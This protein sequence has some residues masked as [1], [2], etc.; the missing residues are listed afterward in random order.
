MTN[1]IG[2]RFGLLVSITELEPIMR[3]NG[4]KRRY[5]Q[6]RCDCGGT[7][8]SS[9]DNLK[10]GK[11]NNCGCASIMH[12]MAGSKIY[13]VW[14]RVV[15]CTT[16]TNYVHY[17]NYGGRGICVHPDWLK[18]KPF[19]SWAVESGYAAGLSIERI[20][21]DGGYTPDNC[22]WIPMRD[23]AKNRRT[24]VWVSYNGSDVTASDYARLTDTPLTTVLYRLRKIAG[25][26]H[27]L[28]KP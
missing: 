14:R 25:V 4:R 9:V 13:G 18:F 26:H 28:Q 10:S 2:V 27:A 21:N 19:Y 12:G 23:Q 16:D 24:T 17:K 7:K 6:C 11:T 15:Q 3:S 22:T 8:I 5:F 1:L 20:D